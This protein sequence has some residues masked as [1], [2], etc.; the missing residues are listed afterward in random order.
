MCWFFELYFENPQQAVEN[1]QTN[2]NSQQL[3]V[4]CIDETIF[5]ILWGHHIQIIGK[6]RKKG[7]YGNSFNL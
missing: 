1:S 3:V 4:D 2:L 7:S 6:C 5:K